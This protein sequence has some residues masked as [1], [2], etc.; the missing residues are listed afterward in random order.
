MTIL[1]TFFFNMLVELQITG[2]NTKV[3]I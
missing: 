1:C 2:A 3:Y